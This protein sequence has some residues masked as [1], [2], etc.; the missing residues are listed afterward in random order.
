MDESGNCHSQQT[1]TRTEN[2]TPHILTHRQSL[3]LSPGTRLECSGV[4]SAHCNLCL[5]GSGNSPALASRV[6]GTTGACHHAQ[7][8]FCIFSR[9]GV[10]PCWP[11]WSRSLDLVIRLPRPRRVL[12][13]Q[14][15]SHASAIQVAGITGTHHHARLIFVFLAEIGFHHIG[16]AGLELLTSGDLPASTSQCAEITVAGVQWHNLD[17]LQPPPP[18]FKQFSHL[19]S[20][21]AEIT[22][23]TSR[24]Q[25]ILPTQPPEY[26]GLQEFHSCYL[27]WSAMARSQL[28]ITSTFWI[29]TILLPQP[30]EPSLSVAR[31]ECN[32]SIILANQNL[33]LLGLSH[34]PA[35]AS[36]SLA[37]LSKAGVQWCDH[38]SLQP[39]PPRI[40]LCHPAWSAVA[41]SQ[42][43]A[44]L[45]SL[46]SE[47][48]FHYVGQ[49]DLELPGS[50][51]PP[52]LASQ[53]TSFTDTCL[54]LCLPGWSAV[55]QSQ[56]TAACASQ[57]QPAL[58]FHLGWAQRLTL[59]IPALWEAEAGRSRGQEIVTILANMVKHRLY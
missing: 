18:G 7:L 17:T 3:A 26:L 14:V 57:V 11:G 53:S 48:E 38:S 12:G 15:L 50:S 35:S 58:R 52:A 45:T 43:T 44:A 31:L 1:D 47:V 19:N 55:A 10:S 33:C 27:D 25:A 8:I 46:G 54:S 28:I 22:A 32:S 42:F 49:A 59:V 40:S 56:L 9:D 21:V 2:Q 51:H 16:Q 13:L 30:P 5:L 4:I 6:A 34:S 39:S 36:Q 24:T 20:G 37:L 29:Q 23:S 41:Q